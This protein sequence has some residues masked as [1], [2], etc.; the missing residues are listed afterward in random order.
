MSK[1]LEEC[2]LERGT[3]FGIRTGS[4]RI[5]RFDLAEL[6][7]RQFTS[8]NNRQHHRLR[9]DGWSRL[10]VYLPMAEL[11]KPPF[12]CADIITVQPNR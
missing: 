7:S 11:D 12:A 1:A 4:S 2:E 8:G 3:I 9:V 6:L 10:L 5:R